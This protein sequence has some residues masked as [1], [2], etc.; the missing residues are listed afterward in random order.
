MWDVDYK[1]SWVLKNWCFWTVVLEK[2]LESPFD[3]KETQPVHPKGN[4]SW[5]YIGRTDIEAETPIFRSP[6]AN[7]WLIGKDANAGKDWRQEEN[8]TTEEEIVGWHH[9]LN[10][11][12]FKQAPGFG[13]GQ[14]SLA[15]WSLWGC[16]D[17]DMTE[18][19]NWT[20]IRS[21]LFLLPV[22][23]KRDVYNSLRL[24]GWSSFDFYT[25]QHPSSTE[26]N[27]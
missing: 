12:E 22:G 11:H 21:W 24:L 3:C 1:E 15:C 23:L 25:T 20:E 18:Q 26:W 4:Q 16:K 10:E 13:D 6:D 5:I 17:S 2:T 27:M 14:G 9:W 8:R 7:N 19:L